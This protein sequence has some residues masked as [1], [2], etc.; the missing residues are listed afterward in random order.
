MPRCSLRRLVWIGP[1][2]NECDQQ[3]WLTVV[4]IHRKSVRRVTNQT[5]H[6]SQPEHNN[7]LQF[8]IQQKAL[9][10]KCE[11][12]YY[13]SSALLLQDRVTL[14]LCKLTQRWCLMLTWVYDHRNRSLRSMVPNKFLIVS[15]PLLNTK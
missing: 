4:W 8:T 13:S 3:H 9:L 1:V 2:R 7:A 15:E 14:L 12:M 5:I 6:L 10:R 11:I